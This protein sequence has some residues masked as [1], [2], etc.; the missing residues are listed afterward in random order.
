MLTG[1]HLPDGSGVCRTKKRWKYGENVAL[2]VDLFQ[3]Q[4]LQCTLIV[5]VTDGSYRASQDSKFQVERVPPNA[6]SFNSGLC[7]GSEDSAPH[8]SLLR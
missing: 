1:G 3:F 7:G 2:F 5:G 6:A 8:E 4:L